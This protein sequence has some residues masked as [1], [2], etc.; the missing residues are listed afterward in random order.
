[1]ASATEANRGALGQPKGARHRRHLGSYRVLPWHFVLAG[2]LCALVLSGMLFVL[3]AGARGGTHD[4]APAQRRTGVELWGAGLVLVAAFPLLRLAP[5]L[6]GPALSFWGDTP[7]HARV[8]AE[9]ARAGLP[10]GWLDS[11]VGGFPFGHHYP[12]LGWLLLAAEIRA[13]VAPAAAVHLLGFCGLLALPLS[14][15]LALIRCGIRPAFAGIAGAFL[16]WVSPYNSFV[17]GYETFFAAGLISQVVVLPLCIWLVAATVRNSN[18]WEAPLAAWLAMASHP[19]VTFATLVLLG[20]ALLAAGRRAF[21]VSGLWTLAM[22]L[23]AGAALYGQGLATLDI[24]LGWPP[25]MG[26]RQLGFE[27]ARL[28]WWLIDADLLDQKSLPV[29]TALSAA[30]L[31]ILLLGAR[32]PQNRALAV[33]LGASL[34]LGVSGRLLLGMGRPGAL[35]LSFLQPLRIMSLIPPLAAVA[36]ALALQQAAGSLAGALSRVGRAG[37]ARHVSLALTLLVGAIASFALPARMRYVDEVATI[38]SQGSVSCSGDERTPAG[39]DRESVRGWLSN[40]SG[41]KLWYDAETDLG[42]CLNRDGLDLAS[43]VPIGST[44]AVGAHVGVLAHAANQLQP[45]RLGSDLRA[46]ALG[47]GYVLRASSLATLPPGWQLEQQR[48]TIQLLSQ[49]AQRVAAG[50]IWQQWRGSP[51]QVRARLNRDL[52][53]PPQADLLLHPQ[54]FTALSYGSGPVEV[55]AWPSDGCSAEQATVS[56]TAES[57]GSIQALVQSPT[58]V[59]VVFRATAFPTWR[60]RVDGKLANEPTLLA[61]GFFSVRVP[62]GGHELAA[63]VRLMPGY[64]GLVALAAALSAVLAWGRAGH[65]SEQL[66]RLGCAWPR[67]R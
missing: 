23:L 27:P 64:A 16:C 56:V 50:C 36:V 66:R 7:S 10:Q 62:P 48:G 43:S 35:L 30:A 67:R 13:G 60:V 54:H 42:M 1:M 58:P 44:G 59:D 37:L 4:S 34:L 31:L 33:A 32:R 63:S 38:L 12:Q 52:A 57:P 5:W 22:A 11:Y 29:L 19:Q 49:P 18:R 51:D 24:P 17:G 28:R 8:A 6:Q 25:G 26:W 53:D 55:S 20:V 14:L 2:L 9:I 39:Y 61:P 40:L 45:D 15:Y 3:R 21:I 47:I 46:Q 41:G 65:A